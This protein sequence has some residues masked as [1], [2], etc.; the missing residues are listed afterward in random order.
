MNDYKKIQKMVEGNLKHEN[1]KPSK[2]AKNL[3]SEYLKG[4]LT[5]Y[6]AIE[7][8]KKYY[9]GGHENENKQ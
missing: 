8:I 6:E 2:N 7:R 9:L 5:S 4:N 3:N 1:I